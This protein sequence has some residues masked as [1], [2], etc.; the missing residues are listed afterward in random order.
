MLRQTGQS[1]TQE[2]R[3]YP[4]GN[5]EDPVRESCLGDILGPPLT[6]LSTLAPPKLRAGGGSPSELTE[7]KTVSEAGV[8]LVGPRPGFSGK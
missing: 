3:G 1:W 5:P 4:S 7:L 6:V 8:L 2:R